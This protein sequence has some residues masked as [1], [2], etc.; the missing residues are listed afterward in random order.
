MSLMNILPPCS[1]ISA[2]RRDKT[3]ESK[4]AFR[5]PG[6]DLALVCRPT[7]IFLAAPYMHSL[8]V[9]PADESSSSR[10]SLGRATCEG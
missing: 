2:C 8:V 10:M 3:L 4:K 1:Q 9:H 7:L 6:C 5:S